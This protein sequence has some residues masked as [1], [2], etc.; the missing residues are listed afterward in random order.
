[1]SETLIKNVVEYSGEP[2]YIQRSD[3]E[4]ANIAKGVLSGDIFISFYLP[5]RELA[6]VFLCLGSLDDFQKKSMVI[7]KITHFYESKSKSIESGRLVFVEHKCL[8]D[9]DSQRVMKAMENG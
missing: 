4:I 3:E 6:S 8:N 5:V 2:R 9:V 1:M 7:D